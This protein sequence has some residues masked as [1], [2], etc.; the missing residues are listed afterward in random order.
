VRLK[1]FT[2]SAWYSISLER[3]I[4]NC[5]YFHK[6]HKPCKHLNALGI[7]SVARPFIPKSHPS[8]SQ[9]LSALVKA[10]RIRRVEDAVYWLVYLDGYSKEKRE[11]YRTGRRLLISS[12]EDGH[13]VAV[14]EDVVNQFSKLIRVE[15][16]LLYLAIEAVRICKVPNWWHP[17]SGGPDYIYSGMVGRRMLWQFPERPAAQNMTRLIE[18]G[19]A[20]RNKTMALAGLLG[21]SEARMGGTKQADF[22]LSLARSYQ[23]S[24]AE[25]LA[26]VHRHAK[27]A[28]SSDNNFLSQA[29][30]MMAGGVSPVAEQS[31]PVTEAEVADLIERAKER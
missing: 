8:Y 26:E 31:A 1:S 5:G 6:T 10:I 4:C 29:A 28:L 21:L 13:S 27:S 25:R 2:S 30:W 22:I 3:R 20:E 9:A 17:V 15:T 12:A 23:H 7:Y 19:I 16:D 24:L 18:E 11:R 14:M